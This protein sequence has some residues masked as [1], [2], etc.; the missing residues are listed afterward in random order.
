M[1][2]RAFFIC[3]FVSVTIMAFSVTMAWLFSPFERTLTD[4][5][6]IQQRLSN[7]RFFVK[8]VL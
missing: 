3:L 1:L 2:P 6:A 5:F 7:L 4:F 8:R